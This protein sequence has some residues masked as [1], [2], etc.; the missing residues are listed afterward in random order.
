MR[1]MA[2][3]CLKAAILRLY[4]GAAFAIL[5]DAVE[6]VRRY[7]CAVATRGASAKFYGGEE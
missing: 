2:R 5:A 4:F 7:R 3:L 1:T 6:K